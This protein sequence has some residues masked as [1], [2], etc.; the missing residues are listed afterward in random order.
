MAPLTAAS[1]DKSIVRRLPVV[2]APIDTPSLPLTGP[3]LDSV[4]A[5]MPA[6]LPMVMTLPLA[7]AA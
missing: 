7:V 6:P 5:A 1:V 2:V 3:E 4:I